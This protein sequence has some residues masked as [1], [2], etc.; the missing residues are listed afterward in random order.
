MDV[1]PQCKRVA[2]KHQQNQ[3]RGQRGIGVEEGTV[4]LQE[5]LREGSRINLLQLR[6]P[7][8]QGRGLPSLRKS[9]CLV[10]GG[11]CC[12]APSG[13]GSARG[14][15]RW[16]D[17][18]AWTWKLVAQLSA[19]IPRGVFQRL[20]PLGFR[21]SESGGAK[22]FGAWARGC[23]SGASSSLTPMELGKGPLTPEG[24][25]PIHTPQRHGIVL[26]LSAA[27]R[28]PRSRP[29]KNGQSDGRRPYP[30]MAL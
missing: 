6:A 16:I 30:L 22:R 20:T 18:W 17:W 8:I 19:S 11:V 13:L 3:R 21:D 15:G 23:C 26:C 14:C 7:S 4:S 5:K 10:S 25:S 29:L 28:K 24:A 2:E 1:L 12:S 27:A 9:Q